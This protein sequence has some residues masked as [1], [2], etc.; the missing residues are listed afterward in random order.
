[1]AARI[2]LTDCYQFEANFLLLSLDRLRCEREVV[3]TLEPKGSA[4]CY[5]LSHNIPKITK[6][7]LTG[8]L[9]ALYVQPAAGRMTL[10]PWDSC[11]A[12]ASHLHHS[13]TPY[14][15]KIQSKKVK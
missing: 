15:A 3:V 2:P 4:L 7:P 9:V 8:T 5:L 1:M 14:H 13:L 10:T 11:A 12:S 6:A